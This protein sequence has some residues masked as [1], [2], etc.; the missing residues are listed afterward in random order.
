MS[1][2][3]NSKLWQMWKTTT[4][5]AKQKSCN[6]LPVKNVIPWYIKTDVDHP[7]A[8]TYMFERVTKEILIFLG[9]YASHVG[10]ICSGK[11]LYSFHINLEYTFH[12][13]LDNCV[14]K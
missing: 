1:D 13:C 10:S 12:L 6:F 7:G 8:E 2:T 4:F 14:K 5:F 11:V 9:S 3:E